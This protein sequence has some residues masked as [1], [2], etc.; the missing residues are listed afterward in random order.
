MSFYHYY[1]MPRTLSLL[2]S[3]RTKF[4]CKHLY[5]AE[6]NCCACW[7]WWLLHAGRADRNQYEL[8]SESSVP[9]SLRSPI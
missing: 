2:T 3:L 4:K 1:I 9:H 6:K 8:R 7:C 5:Q